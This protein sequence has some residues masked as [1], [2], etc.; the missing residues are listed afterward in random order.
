[1]LNKISDIDSEL[2]AKLY[3]NL[4]M[5]IASRRNKDVVS[6]L[7]HYNSITKSRHFE[8]SEKEEIIEFI[9]VF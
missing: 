7:C 2:S 9:R 8:Y 5:R 4:K 3:R 1:M 6:V